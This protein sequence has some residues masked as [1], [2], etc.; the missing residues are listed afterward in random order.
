MQIYR[1]FIVAVTDNASQFLVHDP[2][3]NRRDLEITNRVASQAQT[4]LF[5]ADEALALRPALERFDLESSG[6]QCAQTQSIGCIDTHYVTR[7]N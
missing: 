3:A 6:P 5:P 4:I 1:D 7:H 2:G